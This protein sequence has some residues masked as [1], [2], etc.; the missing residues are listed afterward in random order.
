MRRHRRWRRLETAVVIVTLGLVAMSAHADPI[1]IP[2]YTVTDLGAGTPTLS[3]DAN[4]TGVLNAPN[5]QILCFPADAKHSFDA[6]A[7]DHGGFST[8]GKTPEQQF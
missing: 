7:R 6:W 8:T 1:T 4:G 2:G 5:G 3:T